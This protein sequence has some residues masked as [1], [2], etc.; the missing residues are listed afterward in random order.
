MKKRGKI[1]ALAAIVVV[2]A[3]VLSR[4]GHKNTAA[5]YESR[6]TVKVENPVRQDISLYT[7]LT[8]L[9]EPQSR[10]SV[11]PKMSGEV[12]E[13]YFQAGDT[14]QAGQALCKIDSDA[15]TALKLQVDAASVAL[16]NAD[17]NL[18]RTQA[19]FADGFVSQEAMEQ[20]QNNAQSAKISYE[21]AK[22]QYDLQVKYTTVTAPIDGVIESR[23]VEPHDHVSPAG[24]ICTISGA[25]QLQ[26]KFGITEKI[27]QTM[28][29][30]D[31]V[32]LEKNGVDYTGTVTE[33]GSMVNESSGL[34][35]ARAMVPDAAGLTN[36][37][38]VK[39]TIIMDRVSQV[40]TVPV[41]AVSYDNGAPFVYLYEDGKAEKTEIEAGIYDDENMEVKS[42]L[43]SDSQ[44]IVSWSNELV[45]QGEVLLAQDSDGAQT[46]TMRQ[47]RRRQRQVTKND[48]TDKTRTAASGYH[49]SLS[50]HHRVLRFSVRHG[51]E[52]GT[53]AR[54]GDA[55]VNHRHGVSGSQPGGRNRSGYQERR[56]CDHVIG[57]GR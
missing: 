41:D 10:A 25:S 40:L 45:D 2:G 56:R 8:G 57:L 6:P 55:D 23:S 38:R 29:L 21:S 33:I 35:D 11:M 13:V 54:D 50:D 16:K 12:L 5:E 4:C 43:T 18:S 46:E 51:H 53:D 30:G 48:S 44:V 14:V 26:V 28:E 27:H 52:A 34:Y 9:V 36:G 31:S 49:H 39:M 19:L 1:L 47:Q 7:D 20:A 24:E 42:G 22:N 37:S 3:V 15:L 17:S 32:T